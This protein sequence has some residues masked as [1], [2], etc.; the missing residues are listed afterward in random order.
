MGTIDHKKTLAHLYGPSDKQVSVVDVPPMNFLMVDGV[1]DPNTAPAYQAAMVT[2]YSVA[3][4]LK[5]LL[6]KRGEMDYTVMPLEGLWWVGDLTRFEYDSDKD[7]WHWTSMIMQPDEVSQAHVE[8]AVKGA[9]RK[10]ELPALSAL[11][12]ERFHEGLSAQIMHRGPY[13][14]EKPTIDRLHA[15]IDD[16]G[17]IP[18]GR[19]HEIYLGDP[20]RTAPE[21]LRT[22]IR[23]PIEK[24]VSD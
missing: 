17:Y 2:L 16:N 18:R 15:Y 3:F 24:A 5:F 20:R 11:R 7:S 19:H 22:V 6:K 8:E 14:A 4:T 9:A 12:F 13:S 21:K 23:Q 1:G 10:K